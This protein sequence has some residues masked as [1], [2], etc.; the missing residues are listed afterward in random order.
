VR[1]F[2]QATGEWAL[3]VTKAPSLY[4]Q[5][6]G[7]PSVAQYYPGGAAQYF[8]GAPIW[9]GESPTR[10]YFPP[11][12]IG[13]K[14]TIGEIYYDVAGGGEPR[15]LM[16]QDF[17]ITNSPIDVA[18]GLP[19]VDIRTIAPD[20]LSINYARY[21]YGVR[22]VQGSSVTVKAFWNPAFF[23]LGSDEATNLQQFENWGRNWRRVQTDT[24]MRKETGF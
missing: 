8:F 10:I 24:M 1:A 23:S 3:Q 5:N 21:G 11:M 4:R 9:G 20:A 12:D 14:I 19:Y 16:N 13:K 15:K 6:V 7:A 22:N 18:V 2:Y 17:L